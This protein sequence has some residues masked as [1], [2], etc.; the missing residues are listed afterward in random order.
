M[1]NHYDICIVGAGPAGTTIANRLA[2]FGYKIL[3]VEKS[4]FPRQH[5]GLSLTSGIHH[6]LKKLNIEKKVEALQAIRAMKST[7]L[8][9]SEDPI[10]KEFNQENAGFHIDRGHFDSLLLDECKL[11]KV[12][13]IQPGTIQSLQQKEDGSWDINVLSGTK[14]SHF[15]SS[16]IIDSCGRKS[17]FK[18]KRIAYLPK[19][20]ATYSYWESTSKIDLHSFIEAGSDYWYWGAPLD[21]GRFVLCIFSNP[22]AL[23][24]AS[25]INQFYKDTLSKSKFAKHIIDSYAMG[26]ISVC[27]ATPYFDTNVIGD[28]FI[29]IGDSAYTM[30][31]ISSQGVQKA[32]KSGIQGAIVVNTILKKKNTSLALQYYKNLIQ[33]EVRKNKQWTTDFYSEQAV[34][35]EG[36]FWESRKVSKV[37]SNTN[38]YISLKKNDILNL[39]TQG[40]F[41]SVPILGEK[42]II[43]K[44]GFL[45]KGNEDPFVFVDS[46]H[47]IP[48]LK[49]IHGKTLQECIKAISNVLPKQNPMKL[50]KWLIYQQ[51][52]THH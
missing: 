36:V 15:L 11:K 29:K 38:H 51:V 25:F 41:V 39:N 8:W 1:H 19:L 50:T 42:E 47:I 21:K 7:V 13:I 37:I 5:I 3:V 35:T 18:D 22:S 40:T 34:F 27:D 30:D 44:E 4:N 17:I 52:L 28:N 26:D 49:L 46:H 9:S 6:W 32:I 16:F 2:D 24:E 23:K 31:P 12:T 33:S 45:L 20:M 14:E 43:N 10:I 48:L